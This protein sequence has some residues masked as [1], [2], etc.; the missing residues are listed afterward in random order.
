M[1]NY[2]R[3]YATAVYE[4]AVGIPWPLSPTFALSFYC[5]QLYSKSCDSTLWLS[6]QITT[7]DPLIMRKMSTTEVKMCFCEV[8]HPFQDVL[9]D[10]KSHALLRGQP[11]FLISY[12]HNFPCD[13]KKQKCMRSFILILT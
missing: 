8:I 2:L 7:Q 11:L 10:H 3:K 12:S 13:H 9:K 5:Y 4:V 6:S 1:M